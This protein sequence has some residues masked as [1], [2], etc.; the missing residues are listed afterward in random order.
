MSDTPD[1]KTQEAGEIARLLSYVVLFVGSVGLLV[2]ARTIPA[3]RFEALGAGAF[4]TI[5][6][7]LIALMS[8]GAIFG[9]LRDIP[10]AAY[11]DFIR[12]SAAW[13]RRCYLVFISLGAFS[14][15]LLAIPLLGFSIAS[16]VFL[17]CLQLILMPRS[18]KSVALA[19]VVAVVFSFGL[20]WLFAEVFTVFLPKGAL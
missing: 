10:K 16:F 1:I 19:V 15:Y 4:P 3:S 5:I 17:L 20:N 6:F 12:Q 18:A 13:M 11:G 9:A 8:A 2:A 14:I 7:A